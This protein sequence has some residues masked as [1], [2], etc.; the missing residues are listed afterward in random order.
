MDAARAGAATATA[1]VGVPPAPASEKRP[2]A[3]L[4]IGMAGSGK[5]TLMQR[6]VSHLGIKKVPR[7]I[8]NVSAVCSAQRAR[9]AHVC[10][11]CAQ[12][13]PAVKNVPYQ[14]NVDIRSTINYKEVMR[15]YGLGPNGGIV[16]CLNLFA[17]QFDQVVALCEAR[18]AELDYVLLDT[19]GQIEVFTWSASGAIITD[20]LAVTFPTCVLYVVDTTRT[21]SPATFMSNMLYACSI[22]YKTRLPFVLAFNKCDVAS[23]A[24]P[25]EWMRDSETL[26]DAMQADGS[27]MTSLTRSMSLV[28]QQFYENLTVVSCSAVTGQGM[29]ELFAAL[30]NTRREYYADY[31]A[32]LLARVEERKEATRREQEAQQQRLQAD[33]ASG[34][35]LPDVP[36]DGE[37]ED[38]ARD[39]DVAMREDDEEYY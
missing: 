3:V 12:V 35:A 23:S 8:I 16:T 1:P 13:D 26:H 11:C 31:H 29:D 15:Q 2:T 33:L 37:G 39:T 10:R 20:S 28:L 30:N 32:A 22:L 36:S 27:Y 5:T 7:Y 38:G 18:Q 34:K 21:T 6:M 9:V 25:L 19:P 24:T 17:T 14:P 4:V